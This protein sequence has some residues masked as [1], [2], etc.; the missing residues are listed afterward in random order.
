MFI[1]VHSNSSQ[2]LNLNLHISS[3]P[4]SAFQLSSF[5]AKEASEYIEAT[6]PP[7]RGAILY[8]TYMTTED[9]FTLNHCSLLAEMC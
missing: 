3:S 1:I 9:K 8:G 6:S 5:S 7:R 4:L 2:I